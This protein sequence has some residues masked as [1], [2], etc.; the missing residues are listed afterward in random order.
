MTSRPCTC[1]R[2]L[3]LFSFLRCSQSVNIPD[4]AF[5]TFFRGVLYPEVK[6]FHPLPLLVD[7]SSSAPFIR[8]LRV[9]HG[10][11]LQHGHIRFFDR[12]VNP[13]TSHLEF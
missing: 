11:F 2:V 9:T 6:L 13:F 1:N 3:G 4:T 8:L 10:D 12:E 5:Y 7:K